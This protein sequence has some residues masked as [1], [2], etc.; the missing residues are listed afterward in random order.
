MAKLILD[1]KRLNPH[2]IV[3]I[4]NPAGLM[5]HMPLT[6]EFEEVMN[7]YL[8]R[9]D[10]CAFGRSDKKPTHLWTNVSAVTV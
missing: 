9:V 10:Y 3:V 2:L 6:K 8:T 1:V 7:L 5:K 4:E